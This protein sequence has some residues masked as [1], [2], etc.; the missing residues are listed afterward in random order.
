MRRGQ[1]SVDFL[2]VLAVLL[3]VFAILFEF[4]VKDRFIERYDKEIILEAREQV[5]EVT[6]AINEVYLAGEGTNKTIYLPDRIKSQ[7]YNLTVYDS[8]TVFLEVLNKRES[9]VVLTR[10]FDTTVLNK[11]ENLIRNV[12]GVIVFE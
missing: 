9:A 1:I 6:I 3:I 5:E 7:D 10:H 8:G 4:V 12:G 2:I 11:G